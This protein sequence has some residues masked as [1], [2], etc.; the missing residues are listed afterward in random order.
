MVDDAAQSTASDT[1]HAEQTGH[2][3]VSFSTAARE[4]DAEAGSRPASAGGTTLH[5]R[6][7]A[8][9]RYLLL[10]ASLALIATALEG[11][12][13]NAAALVAALLSLIGLWRTTEG[14]PH[15][16][17]C[18]GESAAFGSR[19]SRRGGPGFE[20]GWW[21]A[22]ETRRP[23]P[24]RGRM[25]L[26]AGMSAGFAAGAIR[27]SAGVGV[28]YLAGVVVGAA[29]GCWWLSCTFRAWTEGVITVRYDVFP[30][31]VGST[32]HV[33][34]EFSEDSPFWHDA[35]IVLACTQETPQFPR[36]GVADHFSRRQLWLSEPR[37]SEAF[38]P[39]PGSEVTVRFDLPGDLP[40][41]ALRGDPQV[42]WELRLRGRT[43]AGRCDETFLLPVLP[44]P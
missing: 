27:H 41:T 31:A 17:R 38:P 21:R 36:F 34:I 19:D 2:Q 22:G 1:D 8:G 4:D 39:D 25:Q 23:I 40:T 43:G 6:A 20:R 14:W 33:P 7:W 16:L 9:P 18:S 12:L 35:S 26:V 10:A 44:T 13:L 29:V 3:V 42:R 30:Y 5:V 37:N 15:L 28:L 11:A 32:V 24:G